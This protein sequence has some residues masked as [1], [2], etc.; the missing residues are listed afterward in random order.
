MFADEIRETLYV[1]TDE[2]ETFTTYA[3]PVNP[4][5]LKVHPTKP[6]WIIIILYKFIK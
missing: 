3:T 6:G 4:R 5:T 1:T 2:G